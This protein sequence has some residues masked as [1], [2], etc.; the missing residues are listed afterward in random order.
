VLSPIARTT[1]AG[2]RSNLAPTFS[3]ICVVDTTM[4]EPLLVRAD[5]RRPSLPSSPEPNKRAAS[6][7]SAVEPAVQGA[8]L[9][10]YRALFSGGR[11]VSAS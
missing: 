10:H 3:A 2:D 7:G 8:C 5:E 9:R 1:P 6:F 11:A 4:L